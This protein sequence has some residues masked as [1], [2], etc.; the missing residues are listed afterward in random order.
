MYTF[1]VYFIAML[2]HH[3][4]YSSYFVNDGYTENKTRPNLVFNTQKNTIS[5]Y[6]DGGPW[7]HS[8]YS[9]RCNY[10]H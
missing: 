5:L 4:S 8:V 10:F 1:F 6:R 9:T 7:F 3:L 2:F